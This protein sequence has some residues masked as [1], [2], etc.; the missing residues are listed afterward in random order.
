MNLDQLLA[1]LRGDPDFL[2]NV[3]LWHTLPAQPARTVSFPADIDPRLEDALRRRSIEELYTHQ[4]QA[5]EHARAGHNTVVVTPT[6]SGKTLCYNLPVL[7]QC[8]EDPQARALYLFPTK[9]L[10][11]DQQKAGWLKPVAPGQ[12]AQSQGVNY[13]QSG[14]D[15][16]IDRPAQASQIAQLPGDGVHAVGRPGA[17]KQSDLVKQKDR[18]GKHCMT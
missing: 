18:S 10:A 9:A 11:Q 5:Y 2:R 3:T 12:A 1:R 8:L 7:Q 17:N 14:N 6:A 16:Q 15:S 13:S 4:A